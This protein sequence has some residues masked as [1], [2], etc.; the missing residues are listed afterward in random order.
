MRFI[1]VLYLHF[2]NLSQITSESEILKL[3]ITFNLYIYNFSVFTTILI[4]DTD[5]DN[6]IKYRI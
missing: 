2:G 4:Y 5:Y 1:Q 3:K 6:D